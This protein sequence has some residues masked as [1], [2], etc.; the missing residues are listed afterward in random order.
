MKPFNLEQALAGKHVMTREGRKVV[1][2]F[3]A[4]E[5]CENSQVICV[6]ETGAVFPY[7]KDG[8]YTNSPSVNDLVM[9][10]TKKEGWI[11]IYNVL[12]LDVTGKNI[13]P[14]EEAALTNKGCDCIATIKIEWE[15]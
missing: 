13:Y 9:A 2:I 5:A 15:E 4:E 10:P 6:L 11:N 12:S 7:Y 14:T 3:Y 8:T 1:R